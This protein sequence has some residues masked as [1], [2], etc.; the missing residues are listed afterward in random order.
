MMWLAAMTNP[1]IIVPFSLMTMLT[2]LISHGYVR[3]SRKSAD[4]TLVVRILISLVVNMGLFVLSTIMNL[5]EWGA[6][7]GMHLFG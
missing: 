6:V 2:L 7:L 1:L 3:Y 5:N 4:Q